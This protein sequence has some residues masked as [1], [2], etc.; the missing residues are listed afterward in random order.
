[1]AGTF[2]KRHRCAAAQHILLGTASAGYTDGADDGDT[3]ENR[4]RAAHRH[5][6]SLV[7]NHQAA[8]PWLARLRRQLRGGHVKSGR[9]VSLVE[10]E[11][12]ASRSSFVHS[13]DGEG[14][15]GFVDD[16]GVTAMPTIW[17]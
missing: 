17:A 15:A 11:L 10:G 1:M 8:Q 14:R 6:A 3:V 13:P 12:R 2:P 4:H 16:D 7:R 5:N 9:G